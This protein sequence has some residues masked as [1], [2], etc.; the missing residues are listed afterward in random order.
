MATNRFRLNGEVY[1][2]GRNGDTIVLIDSNETVVVAAALA[3]GD[4]PET[5]VNRFFSL[6]RKH[7][8]GE[9]DFDAQVDAL[10]DTGWADL[11]NDI[12]ADIL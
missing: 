5:L 2:E 7:F 10:I 4:T 1:T 3:E 6:I 9:P 11:C 12:G 8:A